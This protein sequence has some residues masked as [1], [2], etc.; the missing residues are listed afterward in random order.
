MANFNR[1]HMCCSCPLDHIVCTGVTPEQFRSSGAAAA[2][3][4]VVSEVTGV[5]VDAINV[6][7]T[8]Q[9]AAGGSTTSRRLLQDE[10]R[11]PAQCGALGGG[12]SWGQLTVPY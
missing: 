4:R 5:P 8:P 9:G 10:V 1:L 11:R 3:L 7:I 6:T 2:A 12:V